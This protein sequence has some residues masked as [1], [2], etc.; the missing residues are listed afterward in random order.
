MKKLLLILIVLPLFVYAQESLEYWGQSTISNIPNT[1]PQPA[2]GEKLNVTFISNNEVQV[3]GEIYRRYYSATYEGIE[4]QI[5]EA[6]TYK[7]HSPINDA[8]D[9]GRFLV[10]QDD[11]SLV[12]KVLFPYSAS[13]V[14]YSPGGYY[15]TS[16]I[17][18]ASPSPSHS[19]SPGY[20][21]T[22]SPS[23]NYNST[24]PSQGRTCAG[25]HGTGVC[26]M[27]QGK[28]GYY[29]NSGTYTG[30]GSKTWH[31]CS[32]C[33]GSGKCGVCYGKGVIR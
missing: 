32:S 6:T 28:G 31:Q 17:Q 11:K 7:L 1:Y 4:M 33:H 13:P 27:C 15:C 29:T 5:P 20:V 9:N 30:S 14:L 23:P 21:P 22:P 8:Y 2:Y 3:N 12:E 10:V 16:Y 19:P 24:T 26:T 18:L 25:C